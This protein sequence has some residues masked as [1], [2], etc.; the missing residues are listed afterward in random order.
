MKSMII[1]LLCLFYGITA[2]NQNRYEYSHP[3]MGTVFRVVFYAHHDS[4]EAAALAKTVFDRIDTL[5]M[6][7]S[8]WL[9]ESELGMLCREAGDK[10]CLKVSAELADILHQSGSFTRQSNGAFDVTIGAVTRLWR[11]SRNLKELPEPE[12]I[13]AALKTVGWKNL[14]VCPDDSCVRLRKKGML[15]DLG[16]IAQGWTADDCLGILRSNGVS[17]ALIDAGGD[18][19]LGAPPPGREGW[20][21]EMPSADGTKLMTL[22]NCGITTSGAT[23][24]FFEL[25]GKRYSHIVDPRTGQPLTHRTQVTVLAQNATTADAWATAISVMGEKGWYRLKRKPEIKVWISES[26]L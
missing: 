15:L 24:R 25:D 2:W 9:P 10:H 8:D 22:E 16:G 5:N 23:C 12:R 13:A 21:I 17:M 19:A 4:S 7:F 18:I 1:M 11:R 20:Q 6:R 14:T 26:P 3:Q